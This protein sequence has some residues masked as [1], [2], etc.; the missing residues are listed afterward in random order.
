MKY[1]ILKADSLIN[2]QQ[3]NELAQQGWK[4][5]TIVEEKGQ[6]YFYFESYKL[7]EQNQSKG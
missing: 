1:K 3:L 6:Y 4:L 5:V 7:T 2:E